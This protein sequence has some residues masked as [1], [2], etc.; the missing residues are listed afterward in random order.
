MDIY[1]INKRRATGTTAPCL[2][3]AQNAFSFSDLPF[4]TAWWVQIYKTSDWT[5]FTGITK[6]YFF[7]ISSE[8]SIGETVD[9]IALYECD[10]L[11]YTNYTFVGFVKQGFQAETPWLRRVPTSRSGRVNEVFLTYHTNGDDPSN[12]GNQLTKLITFN[13]G[14]PTVDG[15]WTAPENILPTESG[16]DHTG[17][18][19]WDWDGT[20]YVGYHLIKSTLSPPQ[21]AGVSVS[22]DA[23]NWSRI[24]AVY[25]DK[26]LPANVITASIGHFYFTNNADTF[27]ISFYFDTIS[28]DRGMALYQIDEEMRSKQFLTLLLNEP[29]LTDPYC[30]FDND[31]IYITYRADNPDIDQYQTVIYNKQCLTSFL[32]PYTVFTDYKVTLDSAFDEYLSLG[33]P[34]TFD[35]D[36]Y[37]V[38]TGIVFTAEAA[39]YAPLCSGTTSDSRIIISQTNSKAIINV[40]TSTFVEVPYSF[41]FNTK[42]RIRLSRINN[43]LTFQVNYESS[44]SLGFNSNV[45]EIAN[46]GRGA[47]TRRLTGSLNKVQFGDPING[48]NEFRFNEQTGT[49]STAQSGAVLTIQSTGD[50]THI[51]NNV[52][53]GND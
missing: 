48:V 10:D 15:N 22:S 20:K 44:L 38:F 24:N 47:T 12:S 8:H 13:G 40:G 14:N 37:V 41:M 11:R 4:L 5:E 31:D 52:W 35:D 19:R 25:R 1:T 17:Y 39:G 28:G 53:T 32:T 27:A 45:F 26:N 3:S 9:G 42:Y 33:T 29:G 23:I 49:T 7:L 6:P 21:W 51:N 50:Q 18:F 43:Q 36:F 34:L 2:G 30:Y 16:E 46:V